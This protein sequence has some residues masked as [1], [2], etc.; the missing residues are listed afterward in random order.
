MDA[1]AEEITIMF[2]LREADDE[3]WDTFLDWMKCSGLSR[4][5]RVEDFVLWIRATDR[6]TIEQCAIR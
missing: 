4:Q 3:K 2:G 1:V 6:E 5:R